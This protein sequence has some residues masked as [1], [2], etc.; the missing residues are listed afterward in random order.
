M[1]GIASVSCAVIWCAG[2]VF[3]KV[4]FKMDL[5]VQKIYLSLTP[6]KGKGREQDWSGGVIRLYYRPV[7]FLPAHWGALS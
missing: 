3:Q 2:L 5:G 6:V 1:C 7:K 4:Y